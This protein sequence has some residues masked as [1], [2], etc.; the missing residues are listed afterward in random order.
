MS[1]TYIDTCCRE[2]ARVLK[3]SGYCMTWTDTFCLCEA[4]HLRVAEEL[5]SAALIAWDNQHPGNG[6]RSRRC[7]GYLVVLQ[8]PPL[9]AKATWHDRGIWDRWSEKVDR[10]LHP[11]VKPIELIK[12]LIAA[13]T[14]PGDLVV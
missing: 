4:H 14:L 11:H 10:K 13:T 8:K 6:W 5:K 2:A 9:R 3:P 1:S 12:R 7:G